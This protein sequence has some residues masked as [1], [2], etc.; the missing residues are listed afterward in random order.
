MQGCGEVASPM[1]LNW[2]CASV[3]FLCPAEGGPHHPATVKGL[4]HGN[5]CGCCQA[6]L[7]ISCFLFRQIPTLIHVPASDTNITAGT[8]IMR[9]DVNIHN[10]K[11]LDSDCLGDGE[12]GTKLDVS[13]YMQHTGIGSH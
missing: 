8:C 11:P 6:M 1:P 13:E 12:A 2:D 9:L 4:S 3:Q 7:G 5:T 10:W